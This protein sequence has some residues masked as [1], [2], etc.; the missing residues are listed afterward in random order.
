MF[1]KLF[2][3]KNMLEES[4]KIRKI[5]TLPQPASLPFEEKTAVI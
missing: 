2:G 5:F 3:Y 4:K 1:S